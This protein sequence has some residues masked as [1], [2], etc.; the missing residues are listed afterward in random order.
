M[1]V[2][3]GIV[4]ESVEV[5]FRHHLRSPQFLSFWS[6]Y[7]KNF[8]CRECGGC[9]RGDIGTK[10]IMVDS[11][12]IKLIART[13]KYSKKKVLTLMEIKEGGKYLPTPCPFLSD[14]SCSIYQSRPKACRSFPWVGDTIEDGVLYPTLNI[15]CPSIKEVLYGY[16]YPRDDNNGVS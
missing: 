10:K 3:N 1:P 15:T 7:T 4:R 14:N 2:L 5:V 11:A 6:Y 12:D 13:T 9:C 16:T 8:H